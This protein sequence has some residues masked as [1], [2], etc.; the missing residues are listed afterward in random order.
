MI[1]ITFFEIFFTVFLL[2]YSTHV[3]VFLSC[4]QPFSFQQS[5]TLQDWASKSPY[6]LTTLKCRNFG[7]VNIFWMVSKKSVSQI[8]IKIGIWFLFFIYLICV[9]TETELPCL[10]SPGYIRNRMDTLRWNCF[11]A[12][13]SSILI[14]SHFNSLSMVW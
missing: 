3:L 8:G 13:K 10:F 14:Y 2:L 12:I 4:G 1:V 9:L 7:V 11:K 6:R 5:K